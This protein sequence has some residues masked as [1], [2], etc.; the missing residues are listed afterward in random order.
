MCRVSSSCEPDAGKPG[1][2]SLSGP[3]YG[4][5]VLVGAGGVFVGP[6]PESEPHSGPD[7]D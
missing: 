2:N 1:S 3:S 5:G 4:W 7:A 6:T